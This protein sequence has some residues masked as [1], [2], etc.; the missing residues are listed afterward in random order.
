MLTV[1][2]RNSHAAEWYARLGFT[3]DEFWPEAK[4]LRSGAVKQADYRI[5][6]RPVA[7]V[8]NGHSILELEGSAH[9]AH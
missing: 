2:V 5:L 6:S 1:Y 7:D 4:V 8:E 9:S 3:L